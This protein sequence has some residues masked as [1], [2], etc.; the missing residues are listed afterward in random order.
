MPTVAGLLIYRPGHAAD[1]QGK[2][3]TAYLQPRTA[4]LN[5]V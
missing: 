4:P 1:V 3:G 5:G 2:A